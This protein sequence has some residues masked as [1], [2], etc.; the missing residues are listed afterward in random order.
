VTVNNLWLELR[1]GPKTPDIVYAIVETPKGQR[2]KTEY[3]INSG[4]LVLNRTLFASLHYP[5]DYGL[6][7]QTFYDDG[8]PMDILTMTGEPTFPGCVI[9]VRPVGIFRLMDG[10]CHDDKV[11]GVA[12]T[13][14]LFAQYHALK[15]IPP[16]FLR[17][18]SHFFETYKDLEGKRAR[19]LGWEDEVAAKEAIL[20]AHDLFTERFGLKGL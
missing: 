7:P 16:H 1:T 17:E 12:A 13:D 18:V 15:D 3:N 19:G 5:G 11:L 9:Q 6:I 8:E 14:P 20:R 2:D 10:D 4:V